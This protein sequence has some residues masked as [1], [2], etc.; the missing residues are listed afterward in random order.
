ML[1]I[2]NVVALVTGS[3][4]G[5]GRALV[6]ELERRG[7][8]RV[9]AASR[10]GAPVPGSKAVPLALDVT[11]REQIEAAVERAP[12]V[13]VLINNAG[14]L[15]SYGVLGSELSSVRQDFEINFHGVLE[16]TRA[17][18][19]VL[20]RNAP[21]AISNVL[22]VAALAAMPALG[23]YSAS[24]AAAW[25]LTQ[26]LRGELAPRGVQV[27]A[28]FPGPIDTDMIRSFDL[29]KTSAAD[30]ARAVVD[31]LLAGTPDVFPDPMS[32]EVGA[33]WSRD[34]GAIERRFSQPH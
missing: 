19:P 30:V 6:L 3:N 21:A 13:S 22:S 4:R 25:S 20:E 18:V 7:A 32:A 31:A 34:P 15:A 23:G 8:R 27:Q 29:P 10:S 33:L 26:S 9:Y 28:V 14:L 11:R 1:S 16:T 17:F 12:D 24:K 5:L 2:E